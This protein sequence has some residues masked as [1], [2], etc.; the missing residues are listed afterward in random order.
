MT[1]PVI[2]RSVIGRGWGQGPQH[3]QSLQ[4]LFSHIPG[5]KVVMPTNAYDA[6]G[7]LLASFKEKCPI[8]FIEHRWLHKEKCVVPES[9]FIEPI[10]KAKVVC[11]GDDITIVA[12]SHMVLEAVRVA[13][14]LKKHNISVEVVDLRTLRPW[15]KETIINSFK[16]TGRLVVA[17]TGWLGC[18]IGSEI[19]TTTME[20]AFDFA[21]AQPMRIGLVDSPAPS[22]HKLEQ[23]YYPDVNDIIYAIVKILGR[24]DLKLQ[25][26]K[27]AKKNFNGSF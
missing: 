8:I 20:E 27:D 19:V 6:K 12:I 3:S 10:G 7:L 17:D 4:S 11:K 22:S 9:Y 1:A 26:E 23:Y 18:S 14:E 13:D 24:N 16:K 2:Y 15:D 21:K 5:L 25:F